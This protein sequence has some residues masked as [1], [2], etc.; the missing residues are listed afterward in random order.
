MS[1]DFTSRHPRLAE[2]FGIDLRSLA[3]FRFTLRLVLFI[4]LLRDF[5][6]LRAFYADPGVMPRAWA[7]EFDSVN[8]LS[9]YFLNGQTWFVAALLTIQSVFALMFMLGWRT[10]LAA[11]VS[12]FMWASLI[13]RNTL[14]LIGGDLLM[15]C[16]LFWA[17]F[18][19]LGARYSVDAATASNPPPAD[20]RHLSWAS[21]GMLLQVVSVYFFSALLKTGVEWRPE[22]TG[23]YYALSLDR[24]AT[25][26]GQWL[27]NFPELLRGLSF[28]VW[29]LELLGPLLIFVPVFTKQVRVLLV[30]CFMAMHVGFKLCLELGHFPYVSL[31]SWAVFWGGW[32]WDALAVRQQRRDPGLLRIYY[33]R[34]CGFCLKMCLLLQQFLILPR[35]Q[36]A[37]AQD[38]PRAKALLEANY[39]WV[40]IDGDNQAHM[41]WP[42]YAVLLKHSPLF[43]WLWPLARAQAL[44]KPG[45]A[46]YDWVGRHRGAF[47]RISGALLPLREVRYEVSRNWQRVAGVFI[48]AVF[49][50][51]LAT[52]NALPS[53]TFTALAPVI[54]MLRI[55]QLW[56]MFAPFPLKEDG[57]FVI[58][59]KLADGSEI[60]LLHP[61]RGA[62]DYSKPRHYSQEHENIRWHTYRGHMWEAGYATQRLYYGKYL[63]R[64]WNKDKLDNPT[65]RLMTFKLI[66]MLER[67]PPPGMATQVEQVVL[68]R[69][70]CFPQETKGQVP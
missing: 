32:I 48:V 33:D 65:R 52:V 17:M 70:E 31:A 50:W 40:V 11:I 27:L 21:L 54:R 16:L 4:V 8:R 36:I 34:D 12:F 46:V 57:W 3:L 60:D 22:Y 53:S 67:T 37:P 45:N 49:C 26:L 64:E 2:L 68:W 13:N 51:N 29:W 19:P 63:C 66:Y 42:A 10:R 15:C 5:A 30:F 18:L 14:V 55:D 7:I 43:G 69:H 58:P 20:N 44:V 25:P 23:V 47:G 62:P 56:N 35:A 38:T 28:F 59:A 9:L 24:Y 41:K 6:D 61:D 39:S 1:N